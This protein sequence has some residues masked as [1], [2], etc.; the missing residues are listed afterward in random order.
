MSLMK[1]G[2]VLLVSFATIDLSPLNECQCQW[3]E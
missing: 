3:D 2:S 1:S